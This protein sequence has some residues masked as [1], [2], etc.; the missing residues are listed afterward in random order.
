MNDPNKISDYPEQVSILHV[1]HAVL[2]IQGHLEDATNDEIQ[3][4]WRYLFRS[5]AYMHLEGSL[6]RAIVWHAQQEATD[7]SMQIESRLGTE[8]DSPARLEQVKELP[9]DNDY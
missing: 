7:T 5:G 9:T 1:G 4:A 3:A 6:G 8:H 2:T